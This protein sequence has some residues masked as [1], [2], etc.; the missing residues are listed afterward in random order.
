MEEHLAEWTYTSYAHSQTHSA[1]E[2]LCWIEIVISTLVIKFI[3]NCLGL[4]P[5]IIPGLEGLWNTAY[6]AELNKGELRNI[7]KVL[8]L[9][10]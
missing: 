9:L 7:Y 6:I 3:T 5:S 4:E 8:T 2:N 1:L 10:S